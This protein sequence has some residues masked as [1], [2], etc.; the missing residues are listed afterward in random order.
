MAGIQKEAFYEQRR[1]NISK[2]MVVAWEKGQE[3]VWV[4]G[5]EFQRRRERRGSWGG[6]R[7]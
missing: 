5:E 3:L 4:E 1:E 6:G 7:D 2:T